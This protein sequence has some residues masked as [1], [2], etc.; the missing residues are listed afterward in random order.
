GAAIVHVG[1]GLKRI[2]W[3]RTWRM[4]LS[5]AAQIVLGLSIPL[6]LVE[7]VL[8]TRYASSFLGTDDSYPV[9]LTLTWSRDALRQITLVLVVWTHAMIGLYYAFRPR[10]WFARVREAGLVLAFVVPLLAI[11]GFTTAGREALQLVVPGAVW[12]PEQTAG[13]QRALQI[14]H[15]VMISV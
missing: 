4:P 10:P 11:A 8:G 1:L 7:H 9:V 3:R 14:A 12:T 2:V 13:A 6:L 15:D 5:E